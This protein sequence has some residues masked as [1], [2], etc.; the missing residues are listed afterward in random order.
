MARSAI[1]NETLTLTAD[2][3]SLAKIGSKVSVLTLHWDNQV[4]VDAHLTTC[5]PP[6]FFLEE[7][8]VNMA[9]VVVAMWLLNARVDRHNVVD[10][11]NY[12]HKVTPTVKIFNNES[13]LSGWYQSWLSQIIAKGILKISSQTVPHD[14]MWEAWCTSFNLEASYILYDSELVK[15]GIAEYNTSYD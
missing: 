8:E 10:M 9:N 3:N 14:V 11:D 7:A 4:P 6:L 12:M 2:S 1:A 5:G 15:S 13:V